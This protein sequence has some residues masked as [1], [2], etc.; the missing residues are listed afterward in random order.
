MTDTAAPASPRRLSPM[1][2]AMLTALSPGSV[3]LIL[4]RP[5]KAFIVEP[6]LF[7]HQVLAQIGDRAAAEASVL[8][9]QEDPEQRQQARMKIGLIP[10][11]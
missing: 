10:G 3:S 8:R 2:I 7:A 4:H 9:Q 1:M 11:V 5:E 6:S